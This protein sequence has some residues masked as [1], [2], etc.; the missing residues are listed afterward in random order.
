MVV[1]LEG[2]KALLKEYIAAIPSD[3]LE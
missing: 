2:T 1:S 3:V